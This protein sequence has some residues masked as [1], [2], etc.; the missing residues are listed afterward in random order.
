MYNRSDELKVGFERSFSSEVKGDRTR[1]VITFNPNSANPGEEIYVSIP[2]LKSDSCLVSD[3]VFDFKN[4]N[5]KSWFHN[6]LG[7]L[8]QERLQ[9]KVSGE[10]IYDNTGESIFES[11]KDLWLNDSVRANTIEDGI[12]SLAIRK[13][14]SKDDVS[15]SDADAALA[16]ETFGTKQSF[17]LGNHMFTFMITLPKANKIMTA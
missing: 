2:R 6:N 8:L 13:K 9:I 11:Y 3:L 15:N 14:I 17:H 4:A 1:H 7:R 10:I 16:F 5:T 12:G